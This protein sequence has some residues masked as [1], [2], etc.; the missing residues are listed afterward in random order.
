MILEKELWF[1]PAYFVVVS[2]IFRVNESI[3]KGE[4]RETGQARP[5]TSY[6]FTSQRSSSR[7]ALEG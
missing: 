4:R 6:Y 1:H 5:V 7:L 3:R 2:I